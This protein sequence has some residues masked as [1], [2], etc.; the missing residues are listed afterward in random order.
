MKRIGFIWD[1]IV[2]FE[3]LLWAYNK[4]RRGKMNR[5]EVARFALNLEKE[6]FQL[7]DE[8]NNKSYL[9]RSYR[10]FTIYERKPRQI[11]AA[12][13]R[14][15]VVHHALMG[16][17][18]PIFDRLFI[19]DSYAC[20]K[21]KGVHKAV[22]RYQKWANHYE[23]AL[24]LDVSRYFLNIDH[25]IL[26]QQIERRI[27]DPHVLW[28][29]KHILHHAPEYPNQALVYFRGDDLLTPLERRKG[30]PIG[31]LTSQVM[32]NLYLNNLDHFIKH[33]LKA[34]AYLRYVDDLVLLSHSKVELHQWKQEI[35]ENLAS[36][37]LQL[38]PYKANIFRVEKGVDVL[39][40]QVF[41]KYCLL[42][43][44]NG[45]RFNRRLKQFSKAYAEGALWE[46]FNPSVQSWLGHACH[47]DTLGLRQTI[48][49]N[50][51]FKREKSI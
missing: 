25:Q 17:V 12:A 36:L 44:D 6:L 15:R 18:E 14:D 1:D 29:F 33:Q 24:K 39:G 37:R 32:A 5:P 41:P 31:N 4:A 45:F 26:I 28:L 8:L 27:K 2:S 3:N 48:F 35:K 22:K 10:L 46:S 11:A 40:Y 50:T 30:I 21:G 7:R 9:P 23:Y 20:R 49:N 47:A 42:R 34:K 51:V 38:H 19:Y 13:F 16:I 43:N